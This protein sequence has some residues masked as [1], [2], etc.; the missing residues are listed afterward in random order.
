MLPA[1]ADADRLQQLAAELRCLRS[2]L[3][4]VDYRQAERDCEVLAAKILD[5]YPR[6]ELDRWSF[7]AIS[8]GGLIVLGMLSYWLDLEPHQLRPD[9]AS[10]NPLCVV[11]DCALTGARFAAVLKTIPGR[12]VVFAHLYSPPELRDAILR[13]EDRVQCLAARNLSDQA[14][15]NLGGPAA[16]RSSLE[17]WQERLGPD[18]YW[19]GQPEL[20]AF[21]WSEPDGLFW[22]AVTERVEHGWRMLPPHLCLKNRARLAQPHGQ[23]PAGKWQV[24][25]AV[26][27]DEFDDR[28]CLCQTET[29]KVYSL[30]SVAAD[31]W[32]I[33][34]GWG[35]V[36]HAAQR[37]TAIYLTAIYTV[38]P[39]TVRRDL[40]DFV[41]QWEVNGLLERARRCA[42]VGRW[43]RLP[44]IRSTASIW[45]A[46]LSS[47]TGWRSLPVPP[48]SA[49]SVRPKRR[50]PSILMIFHRFWRVRIE[51]PGAKASRLTTSLPAARSCAFIESPISISGRG[52]P[53]VT[54]WTRFARTLPRS[55]SWVWS[56]PTGSSSEGSRPFMPRRW[57]SSKER[58]PFF[59][60]RAAARP[61]LLPP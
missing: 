24:P 53:S 32:R 13:Q 31:M 51:R 55:S 41:A 52:A 7:E 38:K 36:E 9:P 37:L 19:Y 58:S 22:N 43:G 49:S 17:R 6:P 15:R 30:G 16:L 39:E 54:C 4:Y 60:V 23:A 1:P 10:S 33:L 26:I 20:I 3:R 45:P 59:P 12:E 5:C 57:R 8:H 50:S 44:V 42:G 21:A 29:G 27:S 2:T 56:S 25:R 34:A 18:R 61:A 35:C 46:T 47:P 11:D 40:D 14:S 28:L 48:I